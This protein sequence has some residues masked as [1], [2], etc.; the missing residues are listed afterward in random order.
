LNDSVEAAKDVAK[1]LRGLDAKVNLIPYNPVAG[2]PFSV[3]S[4]EVWRAFKTCSSGPAS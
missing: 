4:F 1:L 2:L 3:P